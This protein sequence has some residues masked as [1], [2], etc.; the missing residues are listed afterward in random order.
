MAKENLTLSVPSDLKGKRLDQVVSALCPEHSR[1][2]I[3][4]WIRAGHVTVDGHRLRQREILQGGEQIHIDAEYESRQEGYARENIPLEVIHADTEI[5]IINKPAGL[6]VHPGAGNPEGTLLNALLHHYPELDKVAR[7]GIV[8]RLDKD[9][10]GLMVIARTPSAHT[11]L[12][13][14]LQRRS[15]TREYQAVVAGVLTAGGT[16]TAPLGRHPVHRTRI[17]VRDSGR[18]AVTHYRVIRRFRAHTHI[19]CRLETGRTHQ[20]RVHMAHIHHP[21]VGD[22][23][24]GGRPRFPKEVTPALRQ[25]LE[26]FPRQALHASRLE[27]VHPATGLQAGWDSP[28]P[29]DM[30]Q[31]LADLDE[32]AR[33][34]GGD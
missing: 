11:C 7:A 17:A 30:Q 2:R 8:Q 26:T 5:L 27:L 18:F 28:L 13:E 29:D 3:Q 15:I 19:L 31:L 6:V 32:D 21:L 22:P 25:Q 20:I 33:S 34:A 9:T 1:S 23:V 12:V 10:S 24:Y 14:Q 16:V 4:S